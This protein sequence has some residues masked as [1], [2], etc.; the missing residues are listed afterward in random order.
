MTSTCTGARIDR[1]ELR[2]NPNTRGADLPPRLSMS[3]VV[4]L[5]MGGTGEFEARDKDPTRQS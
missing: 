5:A 1:D 2:F 3:I 4:T